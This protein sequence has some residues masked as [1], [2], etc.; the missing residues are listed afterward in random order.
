MERALAKMRKRPRKH[1]S[2]HQAEAK[3][4]EAAWCTIEEAEARRARAALFAEEEKK[5]AQKE[6]PEATK[7]FY[8]KVEE[9]LKAVEEARAVVAPWVTKL[10]QLATEAYD[11]GYRARLLAYI[12]EEEQS[13][14]LRELE[15]HF[16]SQLPPLPALDK[17]AGEAIEW[18]VTLLRTGGGWAG[19]R[20]FSVWWLP[21][22]PTVGRRIGEERRAISA[23]IGWK[24]REREDQ[25]GRGRGP[26]AGNWRRKKSAKKGGEEKSAAHSPQPP[27]QAGPRPGHHA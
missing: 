18:F 27:S 5:R 24:C 13:P 26:G 23:A 11:L 4:D 3:P 16:A 6:L 2:L 7:A 15:E 14:A 22:G 17:E 12:A 25:L 1:E 20:L 19:I 8:A 9:I 21:Y 10:D